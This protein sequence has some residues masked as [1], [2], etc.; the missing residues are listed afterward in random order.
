MG[1]VSASGGPP[2]S[3]PHP[4][5]FIAAILRVT[6]LLFTFLRLGICLQTSPLRILF[7]QPGFLSNTL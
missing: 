3:R 2:E 5:S 4:V 6:P 7:G 1:G